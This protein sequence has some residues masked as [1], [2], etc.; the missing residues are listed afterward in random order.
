MKGAEG[1]RIEESEGEAAPPPVPSFACSEAARVAPSEAPES[2]TRRR[3]SSVDTVPASDPFTALNAGRPD[4]C[5]DLG[6]SLA[7]MTT[8]ELWSAIERSDVAPWMRVWREGMECWTPVQELAELRWAVAS[9]PRWAEVAGGLGA[10]RAKVDSRADTMLP[11]PLGANDD[12]NEG[13]GEVDARDRSPSAGDVA[14]R[15]VSGSISPISSIEV[16]PA[17]VA[18]ET[19]PRPEGPSSG[20]RW[21]VAGSM[22]AAMALGFAVV[23]TAINVAAPLPDRHA[24]GVVAAAPAAPGGEVA[25]RPVARFDDAPKAPVTA[26]PAP[27]TTASAIDPALAD[28][29]P[30]LSPARRGDRG[31]QRLPRGGRRAQGR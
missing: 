4:W 2:A 1:C 19:S 28:R 14:A 9:A 7:T 26:L 11:P 23:R 27:S 17:P 24:A 15:P 8:F 12:G 22:V 10:R 18:T 25:P 13:D 21:V 5:V 6:E 16:T 3:R 30:S 31:Q 29:P 20:L